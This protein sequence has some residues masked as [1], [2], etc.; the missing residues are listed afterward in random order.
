MIDERE[1]VRGG[2]HRHLFVRPGRLRPAGGWADQ[3]LAHGIGADGGRQS[4]RHAADRGIE[5]QLA[6]GGKAFDGVGRD[7]AHGH[8]HGERNRQVEVAALLG[9]FCINH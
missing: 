4:T 7:G 3:A 8:H 2:Q 6:D 9:Q 1:E 5:G